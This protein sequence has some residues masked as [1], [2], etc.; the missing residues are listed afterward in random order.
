MP[1]RV[2]PKY[3]HTWCNYEPELDIETVRR[4]IESAVASG[5]PPVGLSPTAQGAPR[6]TIAG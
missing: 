4:A 6:K 2:R 1:G 3:I 5:A